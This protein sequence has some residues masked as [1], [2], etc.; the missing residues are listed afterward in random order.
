MLIFLCQCLRHCCRLL[1]TIVETPPPPPL[2]L[3]PQTRRLLLVFRR[4][5]RCCCQFPS[6][7][8]TPP[9]LTLETFTQA[10]RLFCFLRRRLPRRCRFLRL[11]L[12]FRHFHCCCQFICPVIATLQHP[13]LSL[14]P[15]HLSFRLRYLVRVVYY[16][17]SANAS[18]AVVDYA[19][20]SE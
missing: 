5:H 13:S 16:L 9:P 2:S 7:V 15:R 8:N 12:L 20:Q 11:I 10:R 19:V 14:N 3:I 1:G 17:S 6:P 18:V 4:H